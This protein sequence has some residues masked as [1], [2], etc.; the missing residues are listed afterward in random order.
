MKCPICNGSGK[1]ED[2][3]SEALKKMSINLKKKAVIILHKEGFG[4]RQIQRLIGYKSP[5]SVAVIINKL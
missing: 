2:P 5:R 1:I 4:L 3:R